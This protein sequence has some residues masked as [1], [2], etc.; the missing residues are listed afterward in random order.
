MGILKE[1]YLDILQDNR[2]PDEDKIW[3]ATRQGILDEKTLRLFVVA[4]AR[5]VQHLVKDER[6]I[7]ALNVAERYAHGKAT[8]KD[9]AAARDAARDAARNAARNAASGAARNAAYT[10]YTATNTAYTAY[11]A[12]ASAYAV[13]AAYTAAAATNTGWAA[14]RKKQVKKF[15]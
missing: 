13:D 2:I 4:C 14:A 3:A 6:S 10:A 9:L 1:L 12:A 15:D 5:E 7:K 11:A 8:M